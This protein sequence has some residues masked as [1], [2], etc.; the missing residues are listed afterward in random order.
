MT[1]LASL[2]HMVFL[3]KNKERELEQKLQEQDEINL[4]EQ[5]KFTSMQQEIEIKTKKLKKVTSMLCIIS[6]LISVWV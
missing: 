5:E 1:R 4:E 2:F 3:F 6:D